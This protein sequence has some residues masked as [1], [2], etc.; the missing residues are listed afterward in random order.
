MLITNLNRDRTS[1]RFY[2]RP[3]EVLEEAR[4]PRYLDTSAV[5]VLPVRATDIGRPTTGNGPTSERL[6]V[7]LAGRTPSETNP[8]S[9]SDAEALGL[10]TIANKSDIRRAR[11]AQEKASHSDVKTFGDR[12]TAEH[13]VLLQQSTALSEKS[14]IVPVIQLKGQQLT[15]DHN[16][17]L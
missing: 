13:T 9:L 8:D 17:T 12:M 7:A 2:W 6:A 5:W 11:L 1:I 3:N 14:E 16:K 15:L 10:L 4:H